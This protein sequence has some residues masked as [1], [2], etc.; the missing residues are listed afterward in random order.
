VGILENQF[1]TLPLEVIAGEDRLEATVKQHMTRFKLN[2]AEVSITT[3]STPA[4]RYMSWS[5]N[6]IN[7]LIYC[8]HEESFWTEAQR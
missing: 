4:S 5:S 1:R 6:V 7:C 2:Y 3:A 8:A